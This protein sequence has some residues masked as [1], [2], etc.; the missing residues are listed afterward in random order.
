MFERHV[1]DWDDAYANG[2]NIAGSERWPPAWAEAAQ[3]YRSPISMA[4]RAGSTSPMV[5]NRGTGSTCSCPG[6][7]RRA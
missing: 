5:R 6:P 1:S 3:A 4:A 2:A 7:S